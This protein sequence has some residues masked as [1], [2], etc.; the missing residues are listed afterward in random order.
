MPG[1]VA[2]TASQACCLAP[3]AVLHCGVDPP[4]PASRQLTPPA[5]NL[6]AD[7]RAVW[8]PI[9]SHSSGRLV[10]QMPQ[11]RNVVPQGM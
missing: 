9:V 8:V 5:P 2:S 7:A 1:C 6:P 10:L 4:L 11:N 3:A